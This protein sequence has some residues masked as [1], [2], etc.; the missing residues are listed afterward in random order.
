MKKIK[1]LLEMKDGVKVRTIEELIEHFDAEM[2]L[3]NYI[4]GKLQKWLEDRFYDEYNKEICK[5][6]P[7]DPEILSKLCKILEIEVAEEEL[8]INV[9]ELN[10]ENEKITKLKEFTDDK[11]ILEHIDQVATNQDEF[12]EIL[13]SDS[14]KVFL[15]GTEFQINEA[16]ENVIIT[17]I[18]NPVVKVASK[19]YIDFASK[20]V[21]I[22]DVRF[23]EEYQAVIDKKKFDDEHSGDKKRHAYKPSSILDYKMSDS[24][25][26]KSE[27]LFNI[28]QDQLVDFNY[29]PD[30]CSKKQL[31][32][33]EEADLEDFF[34]IDV[35]GKAQYNVLDNAGLDGLFD[36]FLNRIS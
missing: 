11:Y 24:D 27:E 2:L 18:D 33:L 35:I 13:K 7:S 26:K 15:I 19:V 10:E 21:E 25:R 3:M 34:S 1:F 4:N 29:D 32:A 36:E 20:N 8:A 9:A 16:I 17:G 31:K 12:T 28:I 5:I 6:D 14:D 22:K 30:E 23:D